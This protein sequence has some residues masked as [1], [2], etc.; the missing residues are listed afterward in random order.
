MRRAPRST[1][2]I[3]WWRW[4]LHLPCRA[5]QAL[6]AH[7]QGL[8]AREGCPSFPHLRSAQCAEQIPEACHRR[9]SGPPLSHGTVA[10]V[11]WDSSRPAIAFTWSNAAKRRHGRHGPFLRGKR[12]PPIRR[13]RAAADFCARRSP[14]IDTIGAAAA[15][16]PHT[17]LW[18]RNGNPT[19]RRGARSAIE[20]FFENSPVYRH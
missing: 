14:C 3:A 2:P 18:W 7:A 16:A 11:S 6:S 19:R 13:P 5:H 4:C 8:R 1:L 20:A 9:G 17:R 12:H 15:A 10:G